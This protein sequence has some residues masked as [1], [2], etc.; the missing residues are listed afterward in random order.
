M[1]QQ[2]FSSSKTQSTKPSSSSSNESDA[3]AGRTIDWSDPDALHQLGGPK[4][5]KRRWTLGSSSTLV[6]GAEAESPWVAV[7]WL[8]V[9]TAL[10]ALVLWALFFS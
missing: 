5:G 9:P 8:V 6:E 4:Y 3:P 1:S 10:G 2:D 7:A